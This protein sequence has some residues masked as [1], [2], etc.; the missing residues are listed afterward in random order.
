MIKREK[1]IVAILIDMILILIC[2]TIVTQVIKLFLSSVILNLYAKFICFIV[3]LTLFAIKDLLFHS[4]GLGKNIMKLKIIKNNNTKPKKYL[5]F[6]RN[7]LIYCI[8]V[9]LFPI[10][11]FSILIFN[12]TIID[13]ILNLNIITNS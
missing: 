11:F 5:I 10:D 3:E 4:N 12:R 7:C 9:L 13:I 1:S 6:I 8:N 2:E